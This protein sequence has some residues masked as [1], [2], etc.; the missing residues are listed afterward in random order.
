MFHAFGILM[1][2]TIPLVKL[3]SAFNFTSDSLPF[4][5]IVNGDRNN[6]ITLQV[7]LSSTFLSLSL[8]KG[9]QL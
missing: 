3:V 1:V 5:F 9:S 6:R 4:S 8:N 7:G 2:G